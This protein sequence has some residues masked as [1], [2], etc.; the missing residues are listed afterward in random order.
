MQDH[1]RLVTTVVAFIPEG[2]FMYLHHLS[3]ER[4]EGTLYTCC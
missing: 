2:I 1:L 4:K 3:M